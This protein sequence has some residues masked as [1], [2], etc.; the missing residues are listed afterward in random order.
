[1]ALGKI[2]QRAAKK[3]GRVAAGRAAR[4]AVPP[5]STGGGAGNG[6]PGNRGLTFRFHATSQAEVFVAGTFNGWDPS[7]HPLR[8]SASGNGLLQATL[9]LPPG[10]H[11]YKF[12][13]N[14]AWQADPE[15]SECTLNP[16]GTL[17]SVVE[18]VA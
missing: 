4:A 1:M 10:R 12:I 9:L 15:C 11:E 5:P 16:F 7:L 18:V 6:K 3:S 8:P 17:N 14:G 2:N 13:V